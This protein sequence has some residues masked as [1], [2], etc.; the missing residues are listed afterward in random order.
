MKATAQTLFSHRLEVKQSIASPL[1]PMRPLSSLAPYLERNLSQVIKDHHA[2]LSV[3]ASILEL[4]RRERMPYDLAALMF[5]GRTF[6][7]EVN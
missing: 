3:K 7:P 1:R 5:L 6:P 4:M 2:G